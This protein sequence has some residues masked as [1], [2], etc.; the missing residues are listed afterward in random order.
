MSQTHQD[1]KRDNTPD[2]VERETRITTH[3]TTLAFLAIIARPSI[4]LVG[5]GC[6]VR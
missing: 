6:D 5:G 2:R 3:T 1:A 4:V